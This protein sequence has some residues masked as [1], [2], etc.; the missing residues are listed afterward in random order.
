[1]KMLWLVALASVMLIDMPVSATTT[2]AVSRGN[3]AVFVGGNFNRG[4]TAVFVGGSG[5]YNRAAFGYRQQTIFVQPQAAYVQP[6]I[7]A[8]PAPT[9]FVQPQA[10]YVAPN[11]NYFQGNIDCQSAGPQFQPTVQGVADYQCGLAPANAF[12]AAPSAYGVR[13]FNALAVNQNYGRSAFFGASGY[14][15]NSFGV[16]GFGATINHNASRAIFLSNGGGRSNQRTVFLAAGNQG[17][18]N[19]NV[20]VN[21]GLFG[22]QQITVANGNNVTSVRTGNAGFFGGRLLG[23]IGSA[24]GGRADTTVTVGRGGRVTTIRQR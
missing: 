19:V 5:G 14:G 4:R 10:M 20:R 11:A 22:R 6:A 23:G 21:N 18:Q 12:Y 3:N 15:A 24:R 13:T 16:N 2:V 7:C 9:V 8:Q 1:M 17:G